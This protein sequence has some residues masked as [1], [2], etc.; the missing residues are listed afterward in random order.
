MGGKAY[1]ST[2]RYGRYTSAPKNAA[3]ASP[4]ARMTLGRPRR[5]ARV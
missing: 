5:K 4:R 1:C 3:E 2:S